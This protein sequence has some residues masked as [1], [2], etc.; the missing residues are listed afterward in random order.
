MTFTD[1]TRKGIATMLSHRLTNRLNSRLNN[2]A[3]VAI[4][5]AAIGLCSVATA[6]IAAASSTDDDFISRTTSQGIVFTSPEY[7]IQ[8]GHLVC[9]KL[10]K[11]RSMVDVAIEVGNQ[12]NLPAQKAATL[13][14]EASNAYCPQLAEHATQPAK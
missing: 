13:V 6:G 4:G 2:V 5:A 1:R 3:A 9:T 7:G 11:G 10:A 14:V 8:A 12:T